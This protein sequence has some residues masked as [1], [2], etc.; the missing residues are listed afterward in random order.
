MKK[1]REEVLVEVY[2]EYLGTTYVRGMEYSVGE[3]TDSIEWHEI[4]GDGNW[5]IV[6]DV[7]FYKELE[8]TY[9]KKFINE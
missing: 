1:L 6:K 5:S 3:D 4:E 8:S 7:E 2:I 9:I